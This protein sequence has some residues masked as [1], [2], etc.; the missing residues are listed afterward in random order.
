VWQPLPE[1]RATRQEIWKMYAD[2]LAQVID[3]WMAIEPGVMPGAFIAKLEN[4]DEM[5]RVSAFVKRFGIEV[6]NWYHHASIFLP[7]HQRMT[8][9]HVDYVSGAILANYREGCGIPGIRC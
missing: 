1:I 2:R 4:E 3:P 7:C 6:G 8:R 5:R 9:R